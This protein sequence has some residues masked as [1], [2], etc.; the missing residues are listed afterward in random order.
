MKHDRLCVVDHPVVANMLTVLR[1]K[2]TST[3]KFNS[4]VRLIS[5][6]E[7][8]KVL[9]NYETHEIDVETVMCKTKGVELKT[10]GFVIVPILR[11]G[12]AI[13][14]GLRM[15]LPYAE[16]GH[17]GMYRDPETHLPT[18]YYDKMPPNLLEKDI[19]ITDPMLATGGSMCM[20][21][22]YFRNLGYKRKITCMVL[23]SVPEGLE[24]VLAYDNVCVYTCAVD[25]CLNDD[26]YIVPGL[27][28]A[29]DRIYGTK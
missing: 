14:D 2:N 5:V 10:K 27:G 26:K 28:D 24:K 16:V 6:L 18:T 25:K 12:L 13:A 19:I 23:V 29:G 15:V 1:D 11:A 21:I 3:F 8:Y 22:D 7:A 9:E 17:L 20:A 4:I